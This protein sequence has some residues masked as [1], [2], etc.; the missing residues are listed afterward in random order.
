MSNR[1]MCMCLSE[2]KIVNFF[3]TSGSKKIIHKLKLNVKDHWND[4][5]LA[6]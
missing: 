5:D 1:E 2:V 4:G 3:P 6:I